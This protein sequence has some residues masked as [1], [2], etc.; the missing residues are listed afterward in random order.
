M[1]VR[2]FRPLHRFRPEPGEPPHP[3]QGAHRRRSG[4]VHAA[5]SASPTSGRATPA[6]SS[7]WRDT[8]FRIEGPAVD[9]LRAAFLDNWAETDPVLFDERRRPLPRPAPTGPGRRA[10]RPRCV[11]DRL[12]RRRHAVPHA[13][14][15]GRGPHPDHH[16]LLR[17]RRG[18]DR[19]P[20]RRGRPGRRGRASCSPARTP[21]SGS[22]S[23]PARRATTRLLDA[24][25]VDLEL[26]ALDAARQGHDGRRP[27]R[28]HRLG[29][30]QRALR[31]RSTRRSTS[32]PST[33]ISSPPSTATSTTTSTAASASTRPLGPA[34]AD[35]ADRRAARRPAPP[36][37]LTPSLPANS[38]GLQPADEES[39]NHLTF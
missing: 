26:P 24:R 17:P 11:R 6:T 15:G 9:G 8:H 16:R 2:W 28:Q 27:G 13:P 7:E 19:P 23:S 34:L 5:G 30:P 3:P 31:R 1:Q 12:E 36:L 32:S 18:A 21:T 22:C 39:T 29:Q 4:R 35:P 38:L 20:V 14:P 25:R 10:V 37:L 33:P